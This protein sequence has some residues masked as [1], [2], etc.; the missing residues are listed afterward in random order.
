[1]NTGLVSC[2]V[3]LAWL[4]S[5][6]APASSAEPES[7]VLR[8]D[9]ERI[10]TGEHGELL[11]DPSGTLTI[12]DVRTP[13]Y[14]VRF[15]PAPGG[16]R[17][18]AEAGD[19]ATYWLRLPVRSELAARS[20]WVLEIRADAAEVSVVRGDGTITR[21]T[22]GYG[23]PIAR[24]DVARGD[25][26]AVRLELAAG[27][28]VVVYARLRHDFSSYRGKNRAILPILHRGAVAPEGMFRRDYVQGAFLGVMA[29][30]AMY[31]LIIFA[32]ARSPSYLYYVG[33]TLCSALF[34][35]TYLGYDTD[36]VWP[37][38][39][40]GWYELN[41]FFMHALGV[42]YVLFTITF[43]ETRTRAPR[44]HRCLAAL[45]PIALALVA[46]GFAGFWMPAQYL[47]AVYGLAFM[48]VN[49]AAGVAVY[50]QGYAPAAYFLIA[51]SVF[52]GSGV[53]FILRWFGVP[54]TWWTRHF[55]QLGSTAEAMLLSLALAARLRIL[56]HDKRIA[57][58]QQLRAE[59]MTRALQETNDLK[60]QLLGMA[61][62]DLRNPLDAILG[63]VEMVRD[64]AQGNEAVAEPAE[65]IGESAL[66]MN[67]LLGG[68]LSA[69]SIE[70]GRLVADTHPVHVAALI[71]GVASAYRVPAERKGQRLD[72]DVT[73]RDQVV[74][75]D[76]ERLRQVLDNL[77]NNAVKYTPHGG[78]IAVS[79]AADDGRLRIAVRDSGPGLSAEDQQRLFR[80]F[81]RLSSR[82]TGNETST[83]LGLS[84]VKRI[85]EQHGGR[86]W[87]ESAPG[88]GSTFVV[89]LPSTL[90]TE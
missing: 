3:A 15:A 50:R 73:A 13:P 70:S 86:I 8:P 88:A 1:M 12:D 18:R 68:L 32:V 31:N 67:A 78:R 36:F 29:A 44:L 6:A 34:W 76:E 17:P 52:L 55:V 40:T 58:D 16:V 89:E 9:V 48:A 60:T 77:V 33:V 43:L 87:V 69:A 65:R 28:S 30:M 24:R 38:G 82:P 37:A 80:A 63:Y 22:T 25:P 57:L 42:F 2:A 21:A 51:A 46:L 47:S 41:F 59:A 72:V 83:G 66:R 10:A 14:A 35:V 64:G 61:A 54:D 27:E 81:E 11:L 39:S 26:S 20:W 56:E 19:P 5:L 4:L 74:V 7:L 84:I 75:G 62:H 49:L 85:V 45:P 71:E 90:A 53:V 23:L 79:L